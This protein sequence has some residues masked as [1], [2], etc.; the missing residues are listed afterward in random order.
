MFTKSNR[1]DRAIISIILALIAGLA[2]SSMTVRADDADDYWYITY[3]YDEI[4]QDINDDADEFGWDNGHNDESI[5]IMAQALVDIQRLDLEGC[6]AQDAALQT[7]MLLALIATGGYSNYTNRGTEG[8]PLSDGE[9]DVFVRTVEDV[10][11]AWYDFEC[12]PNE[13]V[14]FEDGS[15]GD[16][17]PGMAEAEFTTKVKH[18]YM[19]ALEAMDNESNAV[20]MAKVGKKKFGKV[21]SY[22]QNNEPQTCE[23]TNGMLTRFQVLNKTLTKIIANYN[24]NGSLAAWDNLWDKFWKQLSKTTDTF[25]SWQWDC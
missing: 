14:T 8:V 6:L 9:Y 20:K 23:H 22:I 13:T 10:V 7:D 4:L 18:L 25:T 15:T 11:D 19:Q 2:I 21:V 17:N 5:A 24:N 1:I 16:S 3:G 12:K